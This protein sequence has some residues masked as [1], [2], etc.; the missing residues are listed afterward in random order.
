M[1]LKTTAI[2]GIACIMLLHSCTG[3]RYITDPVSIKRQHEL[4]SSRSGGNA[5]VVL[6]NIFLFVLS[7]SLD[8]D[9]EAVETERS[10]KRIV[11]KNESP[12][13]TL[14]VNMLTDIE[15]KDSTFCDIMGI[16]LPPNCKQ[17]LLVPYPAAYNVYFRTI[18][19]ED[20]KLEI[21]TDSKHRVFALRPGM[22][23]W[24]DEETESH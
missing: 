21:R 9:F 15:W 11:L 24:L 17:R 14:L 20:E 1:K 3:T 6:A 5:G 4:Q 8:T 19:S 23:N 10:F 12:T 22:T 2:R 7:A 18:N 16:Q 13:D